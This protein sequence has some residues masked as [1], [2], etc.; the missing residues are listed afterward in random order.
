MLLVQY[1][2]QICITAS[3]MSNDFCKIASLYSV[4]LK[5]FEWTKINCFEDI[6]HQFQ[7]N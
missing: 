6:L 1:Q 4:R 2:I 7:E 3:I 5:I